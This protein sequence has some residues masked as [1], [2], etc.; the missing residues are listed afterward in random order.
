MYV[1][2]V[3]D[4]VEDSMAKLHRRTSYLMATARDR[5]NNNASSVDPGFSPFSQSIAEEPTYVPFG[6][7]TASASG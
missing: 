6:P 7:S 3:A 5:S 2:D 1:A 4:T